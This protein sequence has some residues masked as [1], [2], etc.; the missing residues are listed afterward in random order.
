MCTSGNHGKKKLNIKS[1][2]AFL[3]CSW[4]TLLSITQVLFRFAWC[5]PFNLTYILTTYEVST[6]WYIALS[7]LRHR[8]VLRHNDWKSQYSRCPTT[9]NDKNKRFLKNEWY[10]CRLTTKKTWICSILEHIEPLSLAKVYNQ[11]Q[12]KKYDQKEESKLNPRKI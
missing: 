10:L 1:R 6:M 9:E 12:Q 3:T 4:F 5:T 8:H 11:T 7:L 2:A